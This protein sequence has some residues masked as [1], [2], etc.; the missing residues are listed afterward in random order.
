MAALFRSGLAASALATLE[1][2][3]QEHVLQP[4]P[5]VEAVTNIFMVV[6][7]QA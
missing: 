2:H 3:E 4:G 6:F 1:N 7:Y 5:L